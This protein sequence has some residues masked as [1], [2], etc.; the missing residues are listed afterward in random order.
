MTLF[1][2]DPQCFSFQTYVRENLAPAIIPAEDGRLPLLVLDNLRSHW[3]KDGLLDG[4]AEKMFTPPMSCQLNNPI[5]TVWSQVKA[6]F[7]KKQ[8]TDIQR[9]RD[10]LDFLWDL[11]QSVK[12]VVTKGQDGYLRAGNK[13][14]LEYLRVAADLVDDA[15]QTS[16]ED[17]SA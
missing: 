10:E 15:S 14:V 5:E 3:D 2:D 13:Y 6:L 1:V 16:E 8:L 11:K 9:H 4:V 12:E 7:L 17:A